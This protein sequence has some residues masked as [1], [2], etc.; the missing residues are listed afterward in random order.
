MKKYIMFFTFI[1]IVISFC[2][3]CNTAK[4]SPIHEI[5]K[6]FQYEV[7]D[8]TLVQVEEGDGVWVVEPFTVISNSMTILTYSENSGWQLNDT[9]QIGIDCDLENF[10]EDFKGNFFLGNIKDHCQNSAIPINDAHL[11]ISMSF[12]A[13]GEYY[14]Y[15]MN[16]SPKDIIVSNLELWI[17]DEG[18]MD[19]YIF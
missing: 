18:K 5:I 6:D 16:T 13:E 15:F 2:A 3:S 14:I 19:K 1:C 8:G 17:Q 11:R 7:T 9:Q 4:R 10:S 12:G